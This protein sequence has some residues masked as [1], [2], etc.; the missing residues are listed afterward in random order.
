MLTLQKQPGES[1]AAFM[2]RVQQLAS[3][4][5]AFE[6]AVLPHK[7]SQQ[8]AHAASSSTTALAHSLGDRNRFYNS[9]IGG[10]SSSE[11]EDAAYAV[12]RRR[13]GYQRAEDWDREQKERATS[14]S[15]WEERVQFDGLRHGNRFQQNEILRHHL[16]TY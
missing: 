13:T 4:P 6:S 10:L 15:S 7:K 11:E 9:T 3:D 5:I 8:Q 14:S 12:P 2:K 16:K 1:E